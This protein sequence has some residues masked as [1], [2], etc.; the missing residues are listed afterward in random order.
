MSIPSAIQRLIVSLAGLCVSVVATNSLAV[1]IGPAQLVRSDCGVTA[2]FDVLNGSIGLSPMGPDS[3]AIAFDFAQPI[4][5]ED[6][7]FDDALFPNRLGWDVR[8]DFDVTNTAPDILDFLSQDDML[9]FTNTDSGIG[10]IPVNRLGIG[11][12]EVSTN[13]IWAHYRFTFGHEINPPAVT[14]G[15]VPGL[16]FRG[17]ELRNLPY[18]EHGELATLTLVGV[19]FAPATVVPLP[20]GGFLLLGGLGLFG[21]SRRY[22][23]R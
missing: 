11:S 9:I 21:F 8:L 12:S 23:I 17:F 3:I 6:P 4:V 18:I 15:L 20:A 2:C 7:G 10:D 22:L 14:P 19:S 16:S 5:L 1:E 13:G